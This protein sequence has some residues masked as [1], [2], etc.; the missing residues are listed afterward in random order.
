MHN[1]RFRILLIEDNPADIRIIQA[2]LADVKSSNLDLIFADRL[3]EGLDRIKSQNIDAILLDLSLPDS[4]GLK[5][6]SLLRSRAQNIPILLLTGLPDEE[7]A[8]QAVREGAQD[9]LVKDQVDGN[10]LVRAVNYAIERQR[11]ISQLEKAREEAQR[12]TL[13]D[14]LT[15]LYNRRGFFTLSEQQWKLADR[16]NKKLVLLYCDLDNLKTINDNY[17]HLMGDQALITVAQLLKSTFR[18][19]DIIARMG[20]DEFAIL[21]IEAE[22]NGDR[23]INR[24]NE[25]L[26]ELS[27]SDDLHLPISLSSGYAHYDPEQ[28]GSI[29]EVL[30]EADLQMYAQKDGKKDHSKEKT[31]NS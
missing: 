25:K 28:P 15:G 1:N 14:D 18:E 7:L 9:Y 5:T 4:Q 11:L 24:L 27:E 26:D 3:S 22:T 20:G 30:G 17:G 6:F 16:K 29:E 8:I 13:I 21:A 10:L 12:L 31:V 2:L 19:S 23:M